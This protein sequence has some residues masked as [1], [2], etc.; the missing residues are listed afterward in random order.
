ML[1]IHFLLVL[2]FFFSFF[3]F[4]LIYVMFACWTLGN[5]FFFPALSVLG[6]IHFAMFFFFRPSFFIF[7]ELT[8]ILY[9][10]KEKQVTCVCVCVTGLHTNWGPHRRNGVVEKYLGLRSFFFQSFS[11]LTVHFFFEL[12]TSTTPGFK[13]IQWMFFQLFGAQP[14]PWL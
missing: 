14:T 9:K 8:Q 4:F 6:P 13:P 5:D 10:K 11:P 2:N 7:M 12:C 1:H 3:F